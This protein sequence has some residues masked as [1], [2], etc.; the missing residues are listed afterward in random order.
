MA[1]EPS[2]PES[3]LIPR[4]AFIASAITRISRSGGWAASE[5][6]VRALWIDERNAQQATGFNLASAR[7]RE[8]TP[9]SLVFCRCRARR[10]LA[11]L[12]RSESRKM[13]QSQS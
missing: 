9:P 8:C 2:A 12:P 13:A 5:S 10:T 4:A 1:T 7:F 11:A 6:R 3:V